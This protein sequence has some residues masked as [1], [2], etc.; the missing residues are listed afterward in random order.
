MEGL[1]LFA[2]HHGSCL[3]KKYIQHCPECQ[4]NGVRCHL[5]YSTLQPIVTPAVPFDTITI[6]F[7]LGLPKLPNGHDCAMSATCKYSKALALLAGKE[8]DTASDWA[9]WFVHFLMTADWGFPNV[10]I[11]DCNQKF[12]SELWQTMFRLLKVELHFT[13][14]YHP[15]ADGQSERTN[16]TAKIMIQHITQTDL[17]ADWESVLPQVQY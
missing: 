7:I 12:L 13:T 16:Q 11:S 8:T 4:Q 10:I 15:Q 17:E 1:S 5:P 2:V 14:A 3:L 6:D 9:L